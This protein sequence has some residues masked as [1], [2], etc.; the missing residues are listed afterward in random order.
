[1]KQLIQN[2]ISSHLAIEQYLPWPKVLTLYPSKGMFIQHLYLE[3]CISRNFSQD[4]ILALFNS[5]ALQVNK[6][7][8]RKQYILLEHNEFNNNIIKNCKNYNSRCF[9]Y[10]I[11]LGSRKKKTEIDLNPHSISVNDKGW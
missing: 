2:P 7:V 3:Y 8:Y 11:W 6:T 9:P 4:L 1:M 10:V 5:G